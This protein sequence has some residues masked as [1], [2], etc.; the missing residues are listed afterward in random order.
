MRMDRGRADSVS[1]PRL[2]RSV[3]A[4]EA[5]SSQSP[6]LG[7]FGF[8]IQCPDAKASDLCDLCA[9]VAKTGL[10]SRLVSS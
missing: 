5:Q 1:P 2:R 4:T 3:F 7:V 8:G 6:S 10:D 9:S